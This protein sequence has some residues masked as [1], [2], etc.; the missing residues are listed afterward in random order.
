MQTELATQIVTALKTQITPEEKIGLSKRY[1]DNIEAYRLYR[2]GRFSWGSGSLDSAKLYFMKA[3]EL[4]PDYALAY[5]GL[6]DCY[7]VNGNGLEPNQVP[8]AK[9]YAEKALSLDSTLSEALA[10]IGFIQQSFDYDWKNSRKTLE[11]AISL[12]PNNSMAHTSYGLVL[13]HSTS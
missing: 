13:M 8:L 10:T 2:K 11:K 4:E 9:I 5:A 3:I 7:R 12:Y 6:A 1:T